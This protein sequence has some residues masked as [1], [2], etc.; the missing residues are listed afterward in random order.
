MCT[1]ATRCLAPS[2]ALESINDPRSREVTEVLVEHFDG[3]TLWD[4]FGVAVGVVVSA[5]SVVEVW[6]LILTAVMDIAIHGTLP[7][8]RHP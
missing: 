3:G 7:T 8:R 6:P 2:D 4:T 5:I 1:W